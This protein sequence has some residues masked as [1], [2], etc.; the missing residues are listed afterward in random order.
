MTDRARRK[1]LTS[2]YRCRTP[3]AGVYILRNVSN[4]KALLAS[5]TSLTSARN[6]L[7]FAKSTGMSGALDLRLRP[8]IQAFGLDA[9]ELEV[10]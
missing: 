4:G 9:F 5:T 10:L 3:D 7:D 8:E 6:K 1:E 2:S